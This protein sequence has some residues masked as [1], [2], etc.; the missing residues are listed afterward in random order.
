MT[1]IGDTTVVNCSMGKRT[2]G[3]LIEITDT[4]NVL[5]LD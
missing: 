4:L 1:T 3:A 5:I 2:E